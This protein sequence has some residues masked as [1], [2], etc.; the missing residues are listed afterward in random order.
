MVGKNFGWKKNFGQ[1]KIL[2]RNLFWNFGRKI[3]LGEKK[4]FVPKKFFVKFFLGIIFMLK[5][6]KKELL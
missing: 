6:M 1:K 2:V 3:F 4:K 5:Y